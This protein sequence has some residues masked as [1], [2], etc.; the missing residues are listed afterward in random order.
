MRRQADPGEADAE[1]LL[2]EWE[3]GGLGKT[4]RLARHPRLAIMQNPGDWR[5]TTWGLEQPGSVCRRNGGHRFRL[6]KPVVY[7]K[8]AL[9]LNHDPLGTGL[10]FARRTA[11]RH[12]PKATVTTS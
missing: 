6:R 9:G 4:E 2:D 8:D 3:P 5:P 12:Q 7:G 1:A 10:L 11:N